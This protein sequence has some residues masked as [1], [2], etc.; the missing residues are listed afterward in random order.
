MIQSRFLAAVLVAASLVPTA[1][2]L[3]AQEASYHAIAD[4][5]EVETVAVSRSWPRAQILEG[6]L[7]TRENISLLAN[8]R[9]ICVL[10]YDGWKAKKI[11]DGLP[12]LDGIRSG[13]ESDKELRQQ[14]NEAI[15][16]LLRQGFQEADCLSKGSAP[17]AELLFTKLLGGF[18]KTDLPTYFWLLYA[19]EQ[20]G[21]TVHGEPELLGLARP[22]SG[23]LPLSIASLAEQVR[24][25]VDAGRAA[26]PGTGLNAIKGLSEVKAIC[27]SA[28]EGIKSQLATMVQTTGLRLVGCREDPKS[29]YDA[30]LEVTSTYD[31]WTFELTPRGGADDLYKAKARNLQTGMKDFGK[32]LNRAERH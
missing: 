1:Q 32:A 29:S 19:N 2:R 7:A 8:V 20:H 26:T 14:R 24:S 11:I 22:S 9:T 30:L 25:V 27:L 13:L 15:E 31:S 3:R 23:D 5:V 10:P 16:H 12:S 21:I 6:R 4:T 18:G 28:P 17:D